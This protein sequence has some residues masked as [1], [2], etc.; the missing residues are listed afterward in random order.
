MNKKFPALSTVSDL[1]KVTGWL[2]VVVGV[3]YA[4]YEGVWEPNLPNHV[5]GGQDLLQIIGGV[6]LGIQGLLT[7]AFS[8][9]I[10]V[11][12]AIE[13]NTRTNNQ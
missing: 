5:F 1:L 9:V 8:E 11:L 4:A 10:G 6:V 7:F 3:G 12:F 2:L 13:E